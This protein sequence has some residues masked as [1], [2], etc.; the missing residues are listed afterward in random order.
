MS[1]GLISRE[2]LNDNLNQKLTDIGNKDDLETNDNTN[3]VKAINEVKMQANTISTELENLNANDIEARREILDI[4]LK[5]DEN[6]VIDFINKTGIG[7]FDL[8]KD[9]SDIDTASSTASIESTDAIF[10]GEQLLKF[11]PQTFDSFKKVELALYDLN[12]EFVQ[13]D[14]NV[15]NSNSMELTVFPDSITAG[16]KF[17]FGGEIYTISTVELAGD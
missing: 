14:T 8:F 7:F 12:R 5:L 15:D 10:T 9:T 6:D 3:I 2:D 4:K 13:A 17:Y 11:L 16:D 1:D